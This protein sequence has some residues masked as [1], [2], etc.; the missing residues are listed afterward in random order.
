[1]T[2]L[3]FLPLMPKNGKKMGQKWP[4]N[5]SSVTPAL[6]KQNIDKICLFNKMGIAAILSLYLMDFLT[7]YFQLLN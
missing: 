1:M 6:A 3:K 4:K 2:S 5:N 7:H